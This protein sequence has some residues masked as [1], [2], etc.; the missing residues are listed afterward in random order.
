[1]QLVV[2]LKDQEHARC[3]NPWHMP[4]LGMTFRNARKQ[5]TGSKLGTLGLEFGIFGPHPEAASSAPQ[6]CALCF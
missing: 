3:W 1:M 5:L 2:T 6:I 4:S